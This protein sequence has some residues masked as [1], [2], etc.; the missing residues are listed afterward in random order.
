[1]QF[2]CVFYLETLQLAGRNSH[3][4]IEATF[5]AFAR[6]IRQATEPDLRRR[7]SVPRFVF[8][9][10]F[11]EKLQISVRNLNFPIHLQLVSLIFQLWRTEKL[12]AIKL[13]PSLRT[14]SKSF[15]FLGAAQKVFFHELS[16]WK[17]RKGGSWPRWFYFRPVFMDKNAV[18]KTDRACNH[19]QQIIGILM[20]VYRFFF[21]P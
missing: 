12:Q 13:I 15:F 7:G 6:A 20:S 16:F 17:S 18:T 2:S 9:L 21:G 19:F 8:L 5:K 3:H 11:E 4:I 14:K 1:M 10:V